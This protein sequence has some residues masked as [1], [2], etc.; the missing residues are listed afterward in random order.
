MASFM[1]PSSPIEY[2]RGQRI[3]V[4]GAARMTQPVQQPAPQPAQQHAR[5]P[6]PGQFDV[7]LH[8]TVFLD[9]IFTGLGAEIA[10]GTEIFA[11]GMGSSPGGVAN[12]AIASSRL[13]LKTSLAAAFGDDA[14]GD[15]CWR[16]LAD[17]EQIDLSR[18][19][20]FEHWHSPVTVSLSIGG[21]R[22]MVTHSHPAP[23]PTSEMVG[24]PPSARV[25]CTSLA[26]GDDAD[27]AWLTQMGSAGSLIF[28]DVGWDDTGRW[29]GSVLDRL[30]FCHAFMPNAKEAMAYTRTDTARDA[31]Y[32]LADRVPLA[33][34]TTGADGAM[35]ID[36]ASGEEANVP[37]V[38]AT[39]IDPTGA[40]DVFAA[41]MI[42]GTL[43]KWPLEERLAFA[44]LCSALAVQQFGGSLAAPGL[45]DI[46]D[47]WHAVRDDPCAD[48]YQR[49]L[50][51]RYAFLADFAPTLPVER[52]RRAAATIA[53]L[54]D[55]GDGE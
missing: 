53:R 42:L 31:L 35:A 9:I 20:R 16:T 45:G 8:G 46:V 1:G 15:F 7:F 43:S 6:S 34:V 19:R 49:S 26:E 22:S 23:V 11:S 47:W 55:L 13:G 54:S 27:W 12:M 48:S 37:A 50:K 40:G 32:A 28:A 25:V 18:S 14:Y 17:Q 39:A 44:A 5:Q 29:S 4:K 10:G 30:R 36:S 2:H 33:V 21:D 51:H 24:S 3:E 41:G 38:R 52:R